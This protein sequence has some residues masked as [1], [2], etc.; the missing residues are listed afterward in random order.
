MSDQ[1]I[2]V[3]RVIRAS[4]HEIFEVLRD[5]KGHVRIDASGSLMSS[6]DGPVSAVGDRFVIHMD[7]EAI[8]D[9]ALGLYDVTVEIT[10]FEP[11]AEIAW[12][13]STGEHKVGHVYGYELRDH[14]DGTTV[15]SYCDWSSLNEHYRGRVTFPI[16]PESALRNTLG[17]L[18]R[19]VQR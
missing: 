15:T 19:T 5:P 10:S 9:V 11:D 18:A 2:Q 4:R 1:R 16:I 7:R 3:S 12:T 13:V 6:D 17:I 14:E 8:G